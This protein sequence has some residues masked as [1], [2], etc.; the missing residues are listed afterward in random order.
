MTLRKLKVANFTVFND[1]DVSFGSG[2]NVVIGANGAGKSH[3]LKLAYAISAASYQAK[4]ESRTTEQAFS[5]LLEEKI[6]DVFRA[7]Q[8]ENLVYGR[9]HPTQAQV[10][11]AYNADENMDLSFEISYPP[12]IEQFQKIEIENEDE[13]DIQIDEDSDFEDQEEV[14]ISNENVS[15]TEFRETDS[16]KL[17]VTK[18]P[19]LFVELSPIFIP[20]RE[21]L[22]IIPAFSRFHRERV[23]L[24]D[25]TY[26]D[27]SFFAQMAKSTDVHR[28][29]KTI[30][31]D[32]EKLLHGKVIQES[33][34]F[35]LIDEELKLEMPLVAEGLRKI[36]MLCCLLE[37]SAIQPRTL[38][39]WDEPEANL[40]P[41]LM[42]ELAK[43]LVKLTSLEIQ[44][45][46]ATHS[47]FLLREIQICLSAASQT[48]RYFALDK[49]DKII[50]VSQS[51]TI[52][53]IE[54]IAAL[55]ADLEQTDRYLN[56]EN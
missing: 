42:A 28:E 26:F 24:L 7:D 50:H 43:V 17:K 5:A 9:N 31:I 10:S 46:L 38:L 19:E 49:R 48:A 36:A 41:A 3:L 6:M 55:E 39:I 12:P 29:I 15:L 18:F 35:F 1:L 13:T 33:G 54:P 22:S 30:I 47:L 2:M 8:L 27:L 21:I 16:V 14:D 53:E 20:T 44:V 45:V 56:M 4:Q 40:N 25:G 23:L 32:L 37:N 51:D 34:K 52:D 11:I